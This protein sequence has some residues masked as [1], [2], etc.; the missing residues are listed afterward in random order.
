MKWTQVLAASE[1]THLFTLHEINPYYLY[2]IIVIQIFFKYHSRTMED[3]QRQKKNKRE[4]REQYVKI[5]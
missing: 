5:I 3:T 4:L 2:D 1:D